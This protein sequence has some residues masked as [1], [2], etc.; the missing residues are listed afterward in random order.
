MAVKAQPSSFAAELPYWTSLAVPVRPSEALPNRDLSVLVLKDGTLAVGL[1]VGGLDIYGMEADPLERHSQVI[2]RALRELPVDGYL[3]AVF[4]AGQPFDQLLGN[5]AAPRPQTSHS[6]LRRGRQARHA[7]LLERHRHSRCALTYWLGWRQA[8]SGLTDAPQG[9][10]ASFWQRLSRSAA[11]SATGPEALRLVHMATQQLADVVGRFVVALSSSGLQLRVLNETELLAA[12]HRQINPGLQASLGPPAYASS[13]ADLAAYTPEHAPLVRAASLSAQLPLSCLRHNDTQLVVGDPP[14]LYRALGIHRLPETT[15]TSL[16]HEVMFHPD[17]PSPHRVVVTYQASCRLRRKDWLHRRQ[18]TM[19]N[20]LGKGFADQD[21]KQ[22]LGDHEAVLKEMAHADA[23]LYQ[24]SLVVLVQ[25]ADPYALDRASREVADGF[26][27]QEVGIGPFVGQQLDAWLSTLPAYGY[28]A[29]GSVLL[30]ERSCA[31]LLPY[32]IPSEGS[33]QADM[34]L[35]NRQGGLEGLTVRLGGERSDAGAVIV[36]KTGSGKTFLLSH[37]FKYGVL[38]QGGQVILVDNK[39][40]T[41]SSYRPLCEL[42]GGAYISL[43]DSPD[44]S[45]SPFAPRAELFDYDAATHQLEPRDDRLEPL[46]Q[47]LCMMAWQDAGSDDASSFR[48]SVA[49]DLLCLAYRRKQSDADP[50]ILSDLCDAFA[51]Y[52]PKFDRLAACASDMHQR[53]VIWLDNP[54]RARLFNRPQTLDT[55]HALTVFDFAGMD[56]DPQL[57]AVLISVLASRIEAKLLRLPPQLPKLF[58]FD[59]AW[60]MFAHSPQA[61]ALLSRLYRVSR[62]YGAFCYVLTQSY[63]D[64]AHSAAAPGI[65]ANTSMVYLMRQVSHHA[66][67]C[68]LFGLNPRQAELFASLEKVDGK[69]AEFLLVDRTLN[70]THVLRYAPTAFDLW[71]DTSNP[72]DVGLRQ[73]RLAERPEQPLE[74][75]VAELAQR[76]PRGAPRQSAFVDANPESAPCKVA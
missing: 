31:H 69:F 73:A 61:C 67:T 45:F 10:A 54:R 63:A 62:S 19:E 8:L 44:I 65:L 24:T 47:I 33:Q 30:L 29:P 72:V 13:A 7:D 49:R 42:L 48:R 60:A 26:A 14:Q 16:L 11:A 27:R 70:R 59:E 39:G 32:W 68:A 46:E 66:E 50:V 41:N 15:S 18:R 75:V 3:Q 38:D 12:C 64:I 20:F 71:C 6:L 1:A 57:S 76:Y 22:A 34:L 21:V 17:H 23:Q 36:G 28:R 43:Q 56:D 74:D 35:E 52:Q 2:A 53:L 9:K 4:E 40:P 58:A 5:F 37:L 55:Q 51:H 25:G